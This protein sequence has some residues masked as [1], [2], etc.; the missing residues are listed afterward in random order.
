MMIEKTF[1]IIKPDAVSARNT[2]KIIDII[3]QSGF[4]VLGM[5]KL[6]IPKEKAE[7]FYDIH[8]ERPFFKDL[9]NFMVSGPVVVMVLQKENA[10]A[11]WRSLM[12]AT[13][14]SAAA[15]GTLRKL[16]GKSIDNNATHG[17][18][19]PETAAREIALFFPELA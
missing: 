14:P 12:G 9:V 4:E 3:E 8:K 10:I 2:G 15:F 13:N 19:A 16:F 18:D 7:L 5:K 1:A 11:D 6:T 17:S